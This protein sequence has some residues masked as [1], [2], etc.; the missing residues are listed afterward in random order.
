MAHSFHRIEEH[1][2]TV[3]QRLSVLEIPADATPGLTRDLRRCLRALHEVARELDR[4]FAALKDEQLRV[5]ADA[6]EAQTTAL[7]VRKLFGESPTACLVVRRDGAAIAEANAAASRLLNVSQR[8]LIGKPFTNFLQHDR[9]VFLK[10]LQRTTRDA[11]DQWHLAVRPRER[12]MVR[13][14]V[15]AIADNGDTAALRLTPAPAD[16]ADV[17]SSA[18]LQAAS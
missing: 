17:G 11:A 3:L 5:R 16:A 7:R 12:A 14:L 10:Q 15:T 8:H 6:E 2:G 18:P 1:L 13:V 4:A 9:E